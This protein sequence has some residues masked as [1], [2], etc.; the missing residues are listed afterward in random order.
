MKAFLAELTWRGL[1]QDAT[2]GL[3]ERLATG[4]PITAYV[5]FDPTAPSLQ[6]GNLVPVMLLSHLQRA[7]GKAIVVMGGGTG[8]VGD[9]SGKSE[10]RPLLSTDQLDAN[11]R[12]QE[13]QFRHLLPGVEIVDNAT[14][15]RPLGMMEFLRDVGKHFTISVMLQKDS[16]KSRLEQGI[17]FTEFSY[18]LTQAY[19]FWHLFRERQ[20]EM[21]MGGS[22]QWGNITAGV[23]LIRKREAKEAHCLTAPLITT[24]AGAKFGKSE[25]KALWLD[26]G[27]TAPGAFYNF[28]VNTDDR[29]VEKYL[30]MFTFMAKDEIAALMKDHAANPGARAA[31]HALAVEMT[32]RVHGADVAKQTAEGVR[33]AF[34][35]RESADLPTLIAQ[36]M[37][38]VP[39]KEFWW[40]PAK[41][42]KSEDLFVAG[43]LASSK[44][45]AR[46]LLSGKG[47]Y[48]N[49]EVPEAGADVP[50][51]V[52][53]NTSEGKFVL[54]Q[55]GK[56]TY[57]PLRIV[58]I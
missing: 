57:Q 31:H 24:A 4:K 12:R 6:V 26:G 20:C 13:G 45:D 18:M 2:P 11:V 54:L 14:W 9:P 41:P 22:D 50:V 48:L 34:A 39:A 17:S 28:W 53:V 43:G 38:T 25:G 51:S 33:G 35:T 27:M 46:R 5:G 8:M 52:I 32:E 16:V 55:K 37:T 56:K 3:A 40:D 19:D 58:G 44:G 47:L 30:R 49:R 10:E 42:P 23:E 29:D 1:V 15:L 21:Q 7:G 36:V